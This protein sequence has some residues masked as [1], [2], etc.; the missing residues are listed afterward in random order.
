MNRSSRRAFLR[1]TGTTLA[2]TTG[3]AMLARVPRAHGADAPPAPETLP[4]E[5]PKSLDAAA[6]PPAPTP[7]LTRRGDML[8]NQL[9]TTGVEVSRI[10]LGG[11]HIGMKSQTTDD[12]IKII[13]RAID[14]GITFMDNCWDYN[15]GVSEARMGK[16]LADGYR[17]KVVLMTKIDGRTK[18]KAAEQIEQSLDR[19]KTDHVD[20]LQFHEVIRME[21]PDRIFAEGGAIEAF[22]DAKKSGKTRFIGFTGHKDPA[23][24][25]RMLETADMHGFHFDTTQMPENVMDAQFRSFQHLVLPVLLSKGIG[26]LAM[27][28]FGSGPIVEAVVKNGTVTPIELLHYS[29]TLPVS[30]V[31]T[32][33]DQLDKVDQAL[34]AARTFQPMTHD[35]IVNLLQRVRPIALAGVTEKFKISAYFDGTAHNPDWLG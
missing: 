35:Q 1:S 3:A 29:M 33:M 7:A 2:A 24:H 34:E 15:D 23:V 30:V 9:G 25:L 27:K 8:Y 28:T 20:V 12:S 6:T 19:L 14:H 16:A 11:F 32:G 31:I 26:P 10:G 5:S 22:L 17:E 13:R 21:D 4:P 18:K